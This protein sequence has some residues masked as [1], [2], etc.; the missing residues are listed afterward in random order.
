MALVTLT[1]LHIGV[2]RSL[3]VSVP[4]DVQVRV[5]VP[6]G[7]Q[8]HLRACMPMS[9]HAEAGA[10]VRVLACKERACGPVRASVSSVSELR[11]AGDGWSVIKSVTDPDFE[12]EILE[13]D[14][15]RLRVRLLGEIVGISAWVSSIANFRLTKIQGAKG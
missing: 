8:V 14:S 5:R 4:R 11:A 13:T 9:A 2:P 6:R 12:P 1:G 15:N 10:P 3:R 7:S